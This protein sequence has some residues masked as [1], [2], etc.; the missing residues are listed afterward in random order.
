VEDVT[1][2]GG[3]IE[4]TKVNAMKT[5]PTTYKY[6]AAPAGGKAIQC[7]GGCRKLKIEAINIRNSHVGINSNALKEYHDKKIYAPGWDLTDPLISDINVAGVVMENVDIPFRIANSFESCEDREGTQQVRISNFLVHNGGHM[8]KAVWEDE[9]G[10]KPLP[11]WGTGAP[12]TGEIKEDVYFPP[13]AP[14]NDPKYCLKPADA[15]Y[16]DLGLASP[17]TAYN[18]F[19][20]NGHFEN[21]AEYGGVNRIIA[22]NGTYSKFSNLS[23]K[24]RFLCD[25]D[26]PASNPGCPKDN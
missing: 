9:Y 21:D 13:G 14:N 15:Q 8:P 25:A 6:P 16:H 20:D 4:N 3:I 1:I 18:V 10:R 23:Y 7:E 11:A 12:F 5:S 19:I 2:H 24:V 22:G 17:W 26:G